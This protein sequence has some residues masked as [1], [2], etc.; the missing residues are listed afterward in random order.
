VISSWCGAGRGPEV[1]RGFAIDAAMKGFPGR[2]IY[3]AYGEA[4]GADPV[5]VIDTSCNEK[6]FRKIKK[7]PIARSLFR[8]LILAVTYVPASFPAQYHRPGKA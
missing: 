8:I 3:R 1:F 7:A 4:A 6:S 5:E 2:G